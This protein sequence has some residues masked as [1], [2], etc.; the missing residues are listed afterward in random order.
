MAG[1]HPRVAERT[2]DIIRESLQVL[3][4]AK[5]PTVGLTMADAS[6]PSEKGD[7]TRAPL[8]ETI[9]AILNELE[10]RA[11]DLEAIRYQLR[12]QELPEG[13]QEQ[14]FGGVDLEDL[15]QPAEHARKIAADLETYATALRN[16]SEEEEKRPGNL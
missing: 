9:G 2:E 15:P 10:R 11:N 4:T 12:Q 14:A 16:A 3:I 5:V 13:G 1:G 8:A 7:A 6:D